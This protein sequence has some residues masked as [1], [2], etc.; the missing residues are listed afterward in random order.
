MHNIKF[1]SEQTVVDENGKTIKKTE[2]VTRTWG[3]EP[4]YVKVYLKDMLYTRDMPTQHSATIYELLQKASYADRGM[5]VVINAHLK[6]QISQRLELKG[7]GGINNTITQLVKGKILLRVGRGVYR[8]NPY[9]FGR[10]DWQDI[11]RLRFQ[12]TYDLKGKTY[13]SVCNYA[14]V[15]KQTK[16]TTEQ[17][18]V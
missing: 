4:D 7:I 6:R 5:E 18:T 12:V 10:G 1:S 8:F 3:S 11:S 15:K 13:S 17:K 16:K 14:N 9:L 2:K